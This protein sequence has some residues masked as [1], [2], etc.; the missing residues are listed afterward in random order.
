MPQG[1]VF[2]NDDPRIGAIETA[3]K[4]INTT[5][6]SILARVNLLQT[7]AHAT[8]LG[9]QEA[10]RFTAFQATLNGALAAL[11]ARVDGL[12]A[13][14]A[15]LVGKAD[16]QLK[17]VSDLGASVGTS[18][19]GQDK[20]LADIL[21]KVGTGTG[22]TTEPPPPPPPPADWPLAVQ[23]AAGATVRLTEGR[24][25]GGMHIDND[26]VSIIGQG[27]R[28][29][30]LDGRGGVGA[31]YRLPWGKGIIHIAG[32]KNLLIRGI[33]FANGGG[34]DQKHD[35]EAGFY[36]EYGSAVIEDCAFDGCENGGYAQPREFNGRMPSWT[37]YRRCV[38]GRAAANGMESGAH[39]VYL[40]GEGADFEDCIFVGNSRANTVKL[41][42]NALNLRGNWIGRASG[43][44]IDL[45]GGTVLRSTGNTYVTLPG[46]PSNNCFG[47]NDE[48]DPGDNTD[49]DGDAI[50]DG[51][52]FIFGG[53]WKEVFWINHPNAKVLFK[54]IKVFWYGDVPPAV[55]FSRD[56]GGTDLI[57]FAGNP[58]GPDRFTAANRLPG[59]PSP[60]ADPVYVAA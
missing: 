41:R 26:N 42:G 51:D 6:G 3:V 5:A 33:G 8:T 56:V 58:F 43:R 12:I 46:A 24:K 48:G 21:A 39:D 55:V 25:L 7:T 54:N 35:G 45:P 23:P 53:R 47:L 44:I 31:G 20:A 30:I 1:T 14:H 17:A 36:N 28:K 40:G 4:A 9:T 52:T 50:F 57:D 59:P 34:A 10:D 27:M 15:G 29:T 38:F 32:A 16:A 60:P 37:T 13:S 19:A 18:Q 49:G 22:G 2:I 11:A